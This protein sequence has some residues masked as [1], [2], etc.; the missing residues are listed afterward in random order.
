MHPGQTLF[1][2]TRSIVVAKRMGSDEQG[3]AETPRP[4]WYGWHYAETT[5]RNYLPQPIR[6][7]PYQVVPS[8]KGDPECEIQRQRIHARSNEGRTEEHDETDMAILVERNRDR[9][10]EDVTKILEVRP[11]S[12]DFIVGRRSNCL[13]FHGTVL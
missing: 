10:N 8:H 12:T 5:K 13:G 2:T 7:S 3:N 9:M 1:I 6:D 4:C 11:S